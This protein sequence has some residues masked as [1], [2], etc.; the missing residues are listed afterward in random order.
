M[1]DRITEAELAQ[2][3]ARLISGPGL[4]REDAQR[5]LRLLREVEELHE[6]LEREI[7]M[8]HKA[9]DELIRLRA[10]LRK[11][12]EEIIHLS[13]EGFD[14]LAPIIRTALGGK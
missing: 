8:H 4:V 6:A 10:T 11:L 13:P 14:R 9:W 1:T 5:V 12:D 3:K 2:M 7:T